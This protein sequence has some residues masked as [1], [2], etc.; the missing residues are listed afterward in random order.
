MYRAPRIIA[1]VKAIA[2][3]H[4]IPVDKLHVSHG[5]ALVM[6]GIIP[7]TDD[8]EIQVDAEA[9]KELAKWHKSVFNSYGGHLMLPN[10]VT[11][12]PIECLPTEHKWE[13]ISGIRIA[14]VES[15]EREYTHFCDNDYPHRSHKKVADLGKVA[16]CKAH[17]D[18]YK[19]LHYVTKCAELKGLS[20]AIFDIP[21][22]MQLVE[23]GRELENG[24]R[25][26]TE[27]KDSND[28]S[29]ELCL[30]NQSLSVRELDGPPGVLVSKHYIYNLN[31][32]VQLI[33]E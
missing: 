22:L 24:E 18:R 16:A 26:I 12:W 1:M 5:A 8:I 28:N 29:W 2:L 25:F 31:N 15:L 3:S 30:N 23:M 27:A 10:E 9:W 20:K 11:V 33:H 7:H 17:I 6:H 14:T 32:I 13:T 19:R 21:A 4:N